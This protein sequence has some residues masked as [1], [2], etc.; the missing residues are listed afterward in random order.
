MGVKRDWVCAGHGTFESDEESP[1]CPYSGCDTVQRVFLTPPAFASARTKNIDN[2][3][4]SLARSHG[5]TDI[6]NRGGRA[7]KGPNPNVARQQE[8]INQYIAQ[9]YGHTGWGAVPQGGTLNVQTGAVEGSGPGVAGAL[10]AYGGR[11]DNALAEVREAG[12]LVKKPVLVR[13]DH[14]NLKVDVSKAA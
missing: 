6:S 8:Q 10:S 13:H 14:E 1:L 7:A 11:A 9:R 5:M 2:T 12:A 4:E 3:L